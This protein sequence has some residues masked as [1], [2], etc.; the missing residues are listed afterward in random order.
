M[1]KVSTQLL[2]EDSQR[3][4]NPF[5]IDHRIPGVDRLSDFSLIVL[6]EEALY[7]PVVH[8]VS[9]GGGWDWE[10]LSHVLPQDCLEL[11]ALYQST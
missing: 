5:W 7:V 2:V 1:G 4:N 3:E 10:S 8:F 9:A 6:D 11:L